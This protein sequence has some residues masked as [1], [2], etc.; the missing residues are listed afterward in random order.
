MKRIANRAQV[1]EVAVGP[2]PRFEEQAGPV[3]PGRRLLRLALAPV[4]DPV[5][6]LLGRR[7]ECEPAIVSGAKLQDP[8]GHRHAPVVM[9]HQ[10]CTRRFQLA[11]REKL[12]H[13][14]RGS[15]GSL[16]KL[17]LSLIDQSAAGLVPPAPGRSG[18]LGVA[19]AAA[20]GCQEKQNRQSGGSAANHPS[21]HRGN[22]AAA[23]QRA[24]GL[25]GTHL[26]D[27]E[28]GS[29]KLAEPLLLRLRN[30]LG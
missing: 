30:Q 23:G 19:G 12:G 18:L 4:V 1:L 11:I 27:E 24:T 9:D 14:H 17:D 5:K 28:P 8:P 20:T 29:G 21:C 3:G 25:H 16:G 15:S 10:I 26:A 2:V 22:A 13:D 6:V 7:L